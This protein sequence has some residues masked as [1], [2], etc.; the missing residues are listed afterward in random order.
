MKKQ[1]IQD[2][3]LVSVLMLAYNVGPYISDA[4]EGVLRQD[5]GFAFEL[6]IGEDC[7]TDN[8]RQL[9]AAYAEQYPGKIVLPPSDTNLGIAGNA[10]RTLPW[11]RGKYIA[12]CDGD[13]I[14]TDPHKLR[15]QVQFLE[16]NPDY[17]VSYTD[18]ATI[19]EK[20]TPIPD[21]EHDALRPFY[22]QGQVFTRLL[23]GNFINNSTAVFRRTLIADHE[24]DRDRNY[25]IHD[26][27]MWLH[28]AM[29]SKVHFLNAPTTAY[30][31]HS[32]GVTNSESK[33]RNNSLKL[34][35]SM[36]RILSEFR[37]QHTGNLAE[38][39]KAVIFRKL[40]SLLYRNPGTMQE[41]LGTFRLLWH[42][43]PGIAGLWSIAANKIRKRL[44]LA[45]KNDEIIT[46]LKEYNT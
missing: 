21:P 44:P 29:R 32:G 12:V 13:D 2:T 10:A 25:Y 20:G 15:E 3:P 16:Q 22:A 46:N 7:S 39:E 18:V 34:R 38:A 5:T 40:L 4:I 11:C 33:A 36:F 41:K 28:I 35:K 37:Q 42:Y 14:W 24:I 30:R 43:F 26:Y 27:L 17:G 6:V 8:T 19:S 23:R 45:R 31:K 1:D 9:C